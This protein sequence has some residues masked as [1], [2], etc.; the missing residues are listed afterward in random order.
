MR[1]NW[2]WMLL[3]GLAGCHSPGELKETAPVLRAQTLKSPPVYLNCLL[4]KWRAYAAATEVREIR[5][6][7]RLL[8]S[9]G[10]ER[11]PGALLEVTADERGSQVWLYQHSGAAR[12]VAER[13]MREC[14]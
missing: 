6:G 2:G 8:L 12:D 1:I 14:L 3:L 4:P 13:D 7:Y 11:G 9:E 10:R 5:L